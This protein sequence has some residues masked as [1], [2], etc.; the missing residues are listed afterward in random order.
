M[1]LYENM[2]Q[3]ASMPFMKETIISLTIEQLLNRHLIPFLRNFELDVGAR[4]TL[5]Q[6]LLSVVPRKWLSEPNK[7]PSHFAMAHQMLWML[8]QMIE[9]SRHADK[10]TLSKRV[11]ALMHHIGGK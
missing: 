10:Q 7:V 11:N 6:C 1:Q 4:V 3:F 9:H 5:W 2:M 8:S